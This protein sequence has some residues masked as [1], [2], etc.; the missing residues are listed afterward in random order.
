MVVQWES[1][2]MT[3]EQAEDLIDALLNA[4]VEYERCETWRTRMVQAEYFDLK[5]K[6]V[7]ALSN[8]APARLQ[9]PPSD[10]E[11]EAAAKEMIV[12]MFAPHELP[13]DDDLWYLY[14]RIARAALEAAAKVRK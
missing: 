10:A 4:C 1:E 11:V 8:G 2:V 7:A 6:V 14:V 13:V 5:D 12:E 9:A 3:R